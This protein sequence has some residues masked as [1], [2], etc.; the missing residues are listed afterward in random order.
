MRNHIIDKQRE[1]KVKS[2]WLGPRLV[3]S[4]S[5]SGLTER[6]KDLYGE[7]G[8]KKYHLIN[9]ILYVEKKDLEISEIKVLQL[10][11]KTT[12]TV[13]ESYGRGKPGARALIL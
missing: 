9:L 3:V 1:T 7:N 5:L 8:T 10:N 2:K 4:L 13:I 12:P 6:I 11:R